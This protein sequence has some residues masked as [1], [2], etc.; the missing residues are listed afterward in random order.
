MGLNSVEGGASPLKVALLEQRTDKVGHLAHETDVG[1]TPRPENA[2]EPKQ[3]TGK[4]LNV[5]FS[6][7]YDRKNW[8]CPGLGPSVHIHES[9]DLTLIQLTLATPKNFFSDISFCKFI[10]ITGH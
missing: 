7:P 6:V 5:V 4:E 10:R 3:S 8:H 2:P 1:S 9:R